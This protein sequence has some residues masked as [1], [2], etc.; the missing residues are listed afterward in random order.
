MLL[1]KDVEK[2][3]LYHEFVKNVYAI[4]TINAIDLVKKAV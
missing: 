2:K 3:T 4:Q 1:K